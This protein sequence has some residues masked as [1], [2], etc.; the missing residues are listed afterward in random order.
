MGSKGRVRPIIPREFKDRAVRM[1][2]E[3]YE[4]EGT[5]YAIIPPIARQ[6]GVSQRALRGWVRAAREADGPPP[7]LTRAERE[8]MKALE[9]EVAKLRRSNE[10][11]KSASAFFAAE[12]DR[13]E[14]K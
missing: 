2:L 7:G 9:R 8:H 5:T 6:L 4:E 11:L 14:P 12:L 10:I 1:V 13:P 3:A